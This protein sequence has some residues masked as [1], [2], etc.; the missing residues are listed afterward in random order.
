MKASPAP[1]ARAA[2]L[3][4]FSLALASSAAD[5]P[6]QA[7]GGR[8]APAPAVAADPVSAAITNVRYTVTFNSQTA[9]DRTID[10]AMSFDVTGTAPVLLSLPA[11]TPG[12]YEISNFARNIY[13]FAARPTAA[14]RSGDE[15][16]WDKLDFDTWRVHPAGARS[17]TIST[18][19][20]ADSL[21]VAA[22]WTAADLAVFNGTNLFFYPE[23]R[24]LDY[25]ASVS[26]VTE[27]EWKVATGMKPSTAASTPHTYTAA[28]YHDL[29]DMPFMVGHFD[30][31]S[32]RIADR[33]T[34]LAT[35]PSRSLEG[36]QRA[37]VWRAI[38]KMIPPQV[39]VFGDVPWDSYT[40]LQV[41][42]PSFPSASGLEHQNS[43]LD[44]ISPL[45][46]GHPLMLGL[47][48]HEIFHAWNV[49]R[50]RP[51]ELSPYR[52]DRAQ[53]TTLLWVS[54][55]ITDYY[56][57]LSLVRGGVSSPAAFYEAVTAKI[58]SVDALPPIALEDASLS[59]WIHP[60]GGS[61]DIYY[62]KGSLAGLMLDIMVRDAS[63]NR[64]SLD[65]VMRDLY[66][67]TAR[68]GTGF[69][70]AQWWAAVSR[71]AG[72]KSFDDFN[73]RYIDGR[74]PYPWATMLPIAGMRLAADSILTPQ[75]GV[76]TTAD[77]Q[78]V[79]V[80]EILPGS[81]AA[82][83]GVKVGD[84]ILAVGD[85]LVTNQNFGEQFRARYAS[86]DGAPITIRV[87]RDQQTLSLA[88]RIE[89]AAQVQ[90]RVEEDTRASAKAARIREGILR[91]IVER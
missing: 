4:L 88:A 15:L 71:A 53:P 67:T 11:W 1:L 3:V 13:V 39:A 90:R 76:T 85:V 51:A 63:D 14:G 27:A 57:D 38:E 69:T 19:Y 7:R 2:R 65:D 44:I 78:G 48:A 21:D 91:G 64:R 87:R 46:I 17:I 84:Y 55:G 9:R 52:Y 37:E 25:A 40:V 5:L 81:S 79:V 83:A 45:A 89:I 66:T 72:G 82:A 8:T 49:K 80:A 10:V 29:V 20:I 68:K 28:S 22:A 50:L 47:Y 36:A 43:H 23:G 16:A 32:M 75:L 18:S 61:A 54:E 33:W 42:D 70:A 74:E 41:A 56:A 6:A 59:T 24:P 58:Q 77:S 34:R 12:A 73:R 26:V 30:V 31:D 60:V 35:Y 86:Q 62:N